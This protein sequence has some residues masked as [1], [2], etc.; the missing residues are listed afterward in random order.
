L[1]ELRSHTLDLMVEAHDDVRL[2]RKLAKD[3][4]AL[5][6]KAGKWTRAKP[7][8]GA[9][10]DMRQEARSLLADARRL[11]AQALA[12]LLDQATVLCATLTG[13]DDELLGSRTFDLAV[14]DEAGQC[15]EPANWLPI[16]RCG[17]L[18]LAGDHY[19]LPPTVLSQE[20]ARQGFGVSL[21]ERVVERYGKHVTRRLTVQYRMHEAIMRFPSEHFYDGALAAHP[22]VAGHLLNQLPGVKSEEATAVPVTFLDTAGAGFEE[23]LEPDGQSRLNPAEA[24]L[25]ARKVEELLRAGLPAGD[26]AVIAPYAAQ[27]RHLRVRLPVPGL[28]IDSVDGFQGR[29]KEAVILSLVRSNPE[30][31]IGF[32]AD[33]RRTNVALTRARRRLLVVGD[34]ATLSAH[35]FYAALI[36]YFES[37]DAYRTVW[38]EPAL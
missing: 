6:R 10:R 1:P 36:T 24:E 11:E 30:G 12:H 22:V 13:L 23:Q 35:P 17:R 14:V 5:F 4:F 25:V 34:S 38:E 7:E 37:I 31:D 28:E 20:A 19:Q 33:V 27:V 3:A 2:A 32:L 29:E 8:P 16:L 21:M 15:T 9:R 18:V 26:L